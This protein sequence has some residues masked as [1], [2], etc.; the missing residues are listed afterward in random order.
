MSLLRQ[1]EITSAYLKNPDYTTVD[2][3]DKTVLHHLL[4]RVGSTAFLDCV[5]KE[6]FREEG[7]QLRVAKEVSDALIDA[8]FHTSVTFQDIPWPKR[9]LEVYFDDPTIPT[10]LMAK[11]PWAEIT[12]TFAHLGFVPDIR[13]AL[14]SQQNP[15]D[16]ICFLGLLSLGNGEASVITLAAETW[17]AFLRGEL[18]QLDHRLAVDALEGGVGR[19]LCSLALRVLAYASIPQAVATPLTRKQM[20]A[21]GKAG[22]KGRPDRPNIRVVYLPRTYFEDGSAKDKPKGGTVEYRAAHLRYFR[23]ERFV[24]MKGK[25]VFVRAV[26]T[27]P[28]AS[29]NY[30]VV[31]HQ[32]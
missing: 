24:N 10:F 20:Q 27:P 16:E 14:S 5:L 7:A 26:G 12:Q 31:K 6:R 8:D 19:E 3:L 32:K 15:Q 13:R 11:L 9:V 23:H 1:H 4:R 2:G 21:G 29:T 28:A 22:I 25:F 18:K 17:D 30:R